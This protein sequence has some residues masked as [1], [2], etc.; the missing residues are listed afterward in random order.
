[1]QGRSLVVRPIGVVRS[2]FVEKAD[3]PRQASAPGARD[4]VGRVELLPE[5]E[6]ALADLDRFDRIWIL[7]WFDRAEGW[8]AKVL[9]P[10]SEHK[11]GLFATRSP[12]RPNPIGMSCVRLERVDGRV[13]HVRDLD[14]LDGTPVIDLKPYIAYADAFPEA[15]AGWLDAP[16]DPKEAWSVAFSPLA[17]EQLAWIARETGLDLRARVAE[18]LALGPS[19]HPYRRIKRLDDGASILAAKEWRAR[20]TVDGRAIVVERVDSG[21]RAKELASREGPVLDVHRAFVARFG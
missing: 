5:Y 19:P 4:A 2:P 11:R 13:L 21:Y 9:P 8:S 10:R 7:F 1:M 16:R 17:E 12:H 3:A 15:S 18:T 14:L 6:H 20:F